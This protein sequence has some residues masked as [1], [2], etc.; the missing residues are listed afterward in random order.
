MVGR[1]GS[2]QHRR[3]PKMNGKSVSMVPS[4]SL[5]AC[6][7]S[8]KQIKVAIMKFW[9]HLLHVNVRLV[10]RVSGEDNHRRPISRNDCDR[11]HQRYVSPITHAASV[12]RHFVRSMN[13]EPHQPRCSLNESGYHERPSHFA[14]VVECETH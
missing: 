12:S 5:M 13:A 4:L 14:S 11:S 10:D 6:W 2:F 1:V 9:I 8:R 3:V 7:V